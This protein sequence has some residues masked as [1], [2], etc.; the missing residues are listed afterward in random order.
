MSKVSRESAPEVVDYG[1]AEDRGGHFDGQTINF[2]SIREDS[3]LAPLLKAGATC[4]PAVS[5]SAMPTTTK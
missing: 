2:T 4:S 1:P 3:D 5:P